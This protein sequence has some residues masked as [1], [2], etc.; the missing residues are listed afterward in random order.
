MR[1]KKGCLSP[2]GLLPAS[3]HS[4]ARASSAASGTGGVPWGGRHIVAFSLFSGGVI[5]AASLHMD[6]DDLFAL[7]LE[8]FKLA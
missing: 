8:P 6:P 7:A 2:V 1:T 3:L 5:E 4:A